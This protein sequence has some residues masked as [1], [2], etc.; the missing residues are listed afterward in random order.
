V[1]P[2]V[3]KNGIVFVICYNP[4]L[5]PLRNFITLRTSPHPP[6]LSPFYDGEGEKK[7]IISSENLYPRIERGNLQI[8]RKNHTHQF[9]NF[10]TS[11]SYSGKYQTIVNYISR[12]TK[13]F[14]N[15]FLFQCIK[16]KNRIAFLF[17]I[18]NSVFKKIVEFSTRI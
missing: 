18:E 14:L 17:S 11:W 9:S 5:L 10:H 6:T 16:I 15:S 3:S 2:T 7:E 12:T 8:M 13:L 4:S 1:G